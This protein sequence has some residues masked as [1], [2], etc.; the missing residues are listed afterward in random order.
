MGPEFTVPILPDVSHDC[1]SPTFCVYKSQCGN[2]ATKTL[3]SS[4]DP[5]NVIIIST[6]DVDFIDQISH[7]V[8]RESSTVIVVDH[9]LSSDACL[10][11]IIETFKVHVI[12][13]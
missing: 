12:A 2:S 6:L 10:D 13:L 7:L 3:L 5:D 11:Q 4:L 1:S 9:I 8:L